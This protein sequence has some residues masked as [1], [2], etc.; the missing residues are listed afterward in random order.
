MKLTQTLKVL[1]QNISPKSQLCRVYVQIYAKF[2]TLP[3]LHIVKYEFINDARF[4]NF[5]GLFMAYSGAVLL[6][7][8]VATPFVSEAAAKQQSLLSC[9][10]TTNVTGTTQQSAVL[11]ASNIDLRV[12]Y[13]TSVVP[14]CVAVCLFVLSAVWT[15]VSGFKTPEMLDRGNFS[16]LTNI[17]QGKDRNLIPASLNCLLIGWAGVYEIPI[18][19][20]HNFMARFY[21]RKNNPIQF[22]LSFS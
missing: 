20:F 15:R 17:G 3:G 7:P 4:F 6:A 14:C 13:W 9:N 10:A 16:V 11:L 22:I 21:L 2:Q 12:P 8:I 18:R 19:L 5:Q 1:L